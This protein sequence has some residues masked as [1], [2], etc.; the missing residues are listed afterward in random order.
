M[1]KKYPVSTRV[2]RSENDNH[3]CAQ[4]VSVAATPTLF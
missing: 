4:E 2:N 3:E 1:M